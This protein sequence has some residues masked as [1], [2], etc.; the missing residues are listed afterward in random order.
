MATKETVQPDPPTRS[1]SSEY[2]DKHK[3]STLHVSSVA[4]GAGES[5]RSLN[6]ENA[7]H[8]HKQTE[9]RLR[10]K[11]D[12]YV[13]PSVAI[14]WLFCFIDRANIGNARIAGMNE[15]LQLKGYDY[16]ILLSCFYISYILL[17]F[18]ATIL[19]KW[20][21]PGWFIPATTL[22]FG[23]CTIATGFVQTRA[24][25]CV[26][27]FLLGV[28]E[29]GLLPG[30]AYYLSR[31]YRRAELA[32]RLS[33]YLVMSPLAGA[34]GGLLASGILKLDS[35]GSLT[36]WRMIFG[37]EGIVTCLLGV[38]GFFT[39][40]D[41]PETA[42][43]LSEEEKEIC[44]TR[45]QS[46][47]LVQTGE[48]LDKVDKVKLWRGAANPATL[49][50]AMAFLFSNVTVQGLGVFLPS[51]ISTIYPNRSVIQRQLYSVP[52]Y[53]VGS[54]MNLAIP[55]LSWRVDRRQIFLIGATPT[56]II[57]YILFLASESPNVRY[58]ACFL[59]ASTAFIIGPL[60]GAQVSA[61]VVSDTSRSSAI[62]T[63]VLF[64]NTGGL[65]SSW[66]FLAREAPNYPTGNGLNL[67]CAI[68]QLVV[69]L[70]A[71][72]WF[73][74]DNRKRRHRN[75]ERELAGLTQKEIEDLDW[76]HPA[77]R[78]RP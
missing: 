39:I 70:S 9:R 23:V 29:C 5:V 10:L 37:I 65:V 28:F 36:E 7:V 62:A 27:R 14:I 2:D 59:I 42:Q 68:M 60:S 32:F 20:I 63:N 4:N 48:V 43:W 3:I 35:F 58:A 26:L 73:K 11:I 66:T 47:R 21:G 53:I 55:A 56:I 69:T 18:P 57:G 6:V 45:I 44:R 77:F 38:I 41:R 13:V 31:W 75:P 78:W 25:M 19:C 67:A 22:M 40:T 34:F 12:L 1:L 52:P 54:F 50:T 15:S 71:L 17:E 46:E 33:L 16:N 49:S 24:Q 64:G 72:I 76:K 8:I 61:N 51:I 30:I 74:W